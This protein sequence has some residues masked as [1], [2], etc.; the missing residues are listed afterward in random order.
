[1]N[2]TI[3]K[4]RVMSKARFYLKRLKEIK[5][6]EKNPKLFI[7]LAYSYNY[8][9]L[10]LSTELSIK[11]NNWNSKE[12]VARETR[13]FVDE[14]DEINKELK[15]IRA[16]I[17]DA[18]DSFKE[19]GKEPD[20]DELK[21]EYYKQLKP[22]VDKKQIDFWSEYEQY[23]ES[24]KGRVVKDVIKDY[25]SLKKHLKGFEKYSKTT[26]QFT[27]FNF[28][29]YQEFVH[30][31]TYEVKKSKKPEVEKG[32]ATN[33]VG[34]QIKNLK[35]FLNYCFKHELVAQ[36]DLSNF[37]TLTEDT[38]AIYLNEDEISSI[39]TKDLSKTPELIESRDL[40][41]LGC[42]IGLRSSD[43]FRL[44]P[45]MVHNNMIRIKMHKS[46]RTVVIPL[47][48][49]AL[50]I[51]AKYNGDFPNKSNKDTFNADL[52]RI[53][54]EAN[55]DSS[56]VITKKRGTEKIDIV[57]QKHQLIS[58]HTCRRSFCTNQFMKGIP[59]L[60][61]MKIS[62]H[63]TEKAFLR[64]IKIDEEIAAKKMMEIWNNNNNI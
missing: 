22:K 39:Y 42:Q 32:L 9:R 28:S 11:Q 10:R 37:K 43:L 5:K 51:I 58:S 15:K 8:N 13:G 12:Q 4:Y 26:M 52:K 45:D 49:M 16:A 57:Y 55:I 56:V 61:I 17:E 50:E 60:L 24:S 6:T 33:T 53:A 25:N 48:Q 14:A 27:S 1:M 30:Y 31:L 59:A 44:T 41:V 29:F 3:L 34:K 54:K 2:L 35:A 64:Y 19:E 7:Y 62:G 20:T 18:Y 21:T 46:H 36:F 38:D 23:I 40:F 63:K 47:Q